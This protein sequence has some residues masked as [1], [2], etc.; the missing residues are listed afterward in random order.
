MVLG[1]EALSVRVLSLVLPA[2]LAGESLVVPAG[3]RGAGHTSVVSSLEGSTE[4]AHT[5]ES[6]LVI[7]VCC[8]AARQRSDPQRGSQGK[9]EGN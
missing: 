5:L 4:G 2:S 3:R 1:A 9:Q 6:V 8:G 7:D